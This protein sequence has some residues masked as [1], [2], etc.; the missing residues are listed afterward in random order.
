MEILDNILN[1]NIIKTIE[2]AQKNFIESDLGK[3]INSGLEKGLKKI[4]PDSIEDEV[5]EIKNA[6]LEQGFA[7]GVRTAIDKA[8]ETGKNALK[9]FKG[10]FSN[11]QELGEILVEGDLKGKISDV[12]DFT[13]NKLDETNILDDK[14]INILKIGKNILLNTAEL[15]VNED[16]TNQITSLNNIEKYINNWNEA[17][18]E[19]DFNKMEKF[20]N[21]IQKEYDEIMPIKML[22]TKV[23]VIEN[24]QN[25][26]KNNGEKFD[27]SEEEKALA[28]IL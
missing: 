10:D 22:M 4:L 8:I 27:I 26:I 14:I 7:E 16:L 5:I 23:N 17:Y 13:I 18:K 1:S 11:I 3:A 2:N 25:L 19:Q 24:L 12:L 21:K 28:E 20:Y 6:F 9:I 15:G